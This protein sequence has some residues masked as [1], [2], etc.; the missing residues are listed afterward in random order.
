MSL[1]ARLLKPI[2]YLPPPPNLKTTSFC[3]RIH[4]T[5]RPILKNTTLDSGYHKLFSVNKVIFLWIATFQKNVNTVSL[6]ILFTQHSVT[7]ERG[8]NMKYTDTKQLK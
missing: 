8:K 4:I 3:S 2:R 1:E 6:S 7:L 5:N